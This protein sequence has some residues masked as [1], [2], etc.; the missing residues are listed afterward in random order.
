MTS[1]EYIKRAAK[2]AEYDAY[3]IH[4]DV[5]EEERK[6]LKLAA[7]AL[8]EAAK[9]MEFVYG[10]GEEPKGILSEFI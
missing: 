4:K 3:H 5:T 7:K 1:L 6:N 2:R 10:S 8:R 9:A